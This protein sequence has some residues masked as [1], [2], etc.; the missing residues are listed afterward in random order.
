MAH[1]LVEKITVQPV[2]FPKYIS[3]FRKWLKKLK[4]SGSCVY[5]QTIFQFYNIKET[6]DLV[7][8][9]LAADLD[10][11]FPPD[12]VRNTPDCFIDDIDELIQFHTKEYK[13][14]LN[15]TRHYRVCV[16]LSRPSQ[17][18]AQMFPADKF[19]LAE[20]IINSIENAN[21]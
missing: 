9:A 16:I 12:K 3:S 7:D 17:Y 2:E 18:F 5:H 11:E 1:V 8:L 13:V 15:W 21:E 4:D 20:R 10:K 19:W 14:Y 6:P